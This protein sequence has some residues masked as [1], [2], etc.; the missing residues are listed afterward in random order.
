MNFFSNDN[1]RPDFFSIL[2]IQP[3]ANSQTIKKQ[4]R[5][6]SLIHHPDR[7]N[8]DDTMFKKINEAYHGI[9]NKSENMPEVNDIF[10]PEKAFDFFFSKLN[11]TQVSKPPPIIKTIDI[12]LENVLTKQTKPIT[13]ERMIDYAEIK[14]FESETIYVSIPQGIDHGE[15]LEIPKKGNILNGIQGDIKIIINLNNNTSFQRDGLDLIYKKTITLKEA[16]L[17]FKFKLSLLDTTEYTIQ[18]KGNI[19]IHNNFK[20]EIPN[21][22][23]QRD[24]ACG[25]LII[26]FQVCLPKKL[27]EKQK[28]KLAEIL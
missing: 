27:T 4:Y 17:G 6:L 14:N 23:I 10:N 13:I 22:G 2:N 7:N 28:Q 16:L 1:Q 18:N 20:K 15:M 8:G 26:V 12:L 21:L 24:N 19:I 11:N 9:I 5:K 3:G 25:K